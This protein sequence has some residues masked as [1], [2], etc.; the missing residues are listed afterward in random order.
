[1]SKPVVPKE[2]KPRD[3]K[4]EFPWGVKTPTYKAWLVIFTF[5]IVALSVFFVGAVEVPALQG[6]NVFQSVFE[7]TPKTDLAR[8]LEDPN[9]PVIETPASDKAVLLFYCLWIIVA[10]T[11]LVIV[12]KTVG[13]WLSSLEEVCWEQDCNWWC[14]C[15]NKWLCIFVTVLKWVTWVITIISTVITSFL[16]WICFDGWNPLSSLISG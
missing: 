7:D 10:N 16:A 5:N 14:L 11:L 6:E 4:S 9:D 2:K 15:C 1:M 8:S 12:T 3:I 13:G